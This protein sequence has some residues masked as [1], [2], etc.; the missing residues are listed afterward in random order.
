[1]L[2][3]SLLALALCAGANACATHRCS[4]GFV[5]KTNAPN[6]GA[7]DALCCDAVCT[8]ADF[9][10]QGG[11]VK[12]A[13]AGDK[14]CGAAPTN[15]Q[16][17]VCCTAITDLTIRAR[18]QIGQVSSCE[19]DADCTQ[20]GDTEGK[21]IDG[22]SGCKCGQFYGWEEH[23]NNEVRLCYPKKDAKVNFGYTVT[24]GT[25]LLFGG[26]CTT[27]KEAARAAFLN[28]TE[29]VTRSTVEALSV[30]CSGGATPAY[31][32]V[33][34]V[35]VAAKDLH[36]VQENTIRL[37]AAEILRVMKLLP[38]F[39][40]VTTATFAFTARTT[41]LTCATLAA[42]TA[43]CITI[44]A[45]DIAIKCSV[46]NNR[47]V[48]WD[49]ACTAPAGLPTPPPAERCLVNGDCSY[50]ADR[51]VCNRE[52]RL[53][54]EPEVPLEASPVTSYSLRRT[55]QVDKHFCQTDANCRVFGDV[56][57][58]CDEHAGLGNWCK[59]SVGYEYPSPLLPYCMPSGHKQQRVPYSFSI[60]VK[61]GQACP[62]T[63]EYR[64]MYKTIAQLAFEDI[65]LF[66]EYC[67]KDG[68]SFIGKAQ[69][70][71]A[72]AQVIAQTNLREYLSSTWLA[73]ANGKPEWV[74][75]LAETELDFQVGALYQCESAGATVTRY[76]SSMRCQA[77]ECGAGFRLWTIQDYTG[78]IPT[79]AVEE[80]YPCKTQ[81]PAEEDDDLTDQQ[82][83]GISLGSAALLLVL[84]ALIMLTMKSG[85]AQPESTE[86]VEEK[87]A[88]EI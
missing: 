46:P 20:F 58:E 57:A 41:T 33:A 18:P 71:L 8:H 84:V 74:Q 23:N 52:T 12:I 86:P 53:C 26:A 13:G 25:G 7:T 79:N 48:S 81:P 75:F 29:I 2:A 88:E 78:C 69:V 59:C 80:R 37:N 40:T 85:S 34:R 4:A 66:E 15:C 83:A 9:Q 50:S 65:V 11:S 68:L 55:A 51:S 39:N 64:K 82:I 67:T 63:Q 38:E 17:S 19:K 5:T 76:D 1:M 47:G 56:N 35:H 49:T 43:E 27:D 44:T 24:Q 6:V 45:G 31:Q 61:R 14:R 87:E 42:R 72:R 32:V 73:F 62:L 10:C 30:T 70:S 54:V 60:V 3:R 22:H 77:I 16:Q 21:C 28:V 36:Y